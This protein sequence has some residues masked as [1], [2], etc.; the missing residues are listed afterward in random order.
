[1]ISKIV[2]F[3][4]DNIRYIFI[5][6]FDKLKLILLHSVNEI[7]L[8]DNVKQNSDL[9]KKKFQM[10]HISFYHPKVLNW[11]SIII[12]A[13]MVDTGFWKLGPWLGERRGN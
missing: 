6:V 2:V 9:L 7:L 1:M 12:K 4:F 10:Y 3:I 13:V 8:N 11:I 5:N